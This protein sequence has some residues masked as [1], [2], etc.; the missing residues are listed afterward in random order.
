MAN[1]RYRRDSMNTGTG[2]KAELEAVASWMKQ[3]MRRADK[4]SSPLIDLLYL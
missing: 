2:N 1:T 3:A 4:C